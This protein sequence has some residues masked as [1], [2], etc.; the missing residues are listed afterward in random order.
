PSAHAVPG[1]VAV[2]SSWPTLT[3]PTTDHL[4]GDSVP[5][6]TILLIASD[7]APGDAIKTIL[8]GAGYTVTVVADPEEAFAKVAEHQLVVV[9]ISSG[10]ASAVEVC[11][12]IRA[13]PAMSAV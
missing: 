11:R 1:P 6:S 13:T 2:V 12:Q 5:A 9:D 8:S 10:P 7:A 4:R 3:A